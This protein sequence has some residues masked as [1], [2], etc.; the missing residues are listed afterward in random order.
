MKITSGL[1]DN[2]V[3]QRTRRNVCDATV[4]GECDGSGTVY[5]DVKLRGRP[6]G[7]F[8]GRRVGTASQGRFSVR[9]KG[10]ASGG[11]YTISLRL[12]DS[13]GRKIDYTEVKNV[14]VG[15]VW[16]LAGQS[17]MEGFGFLRD[18]LPPHPM[19]RAFSMDSTWDIA[20]DPIHNLPAAAAVV[21][22][23]IEGGVVRREAH[24]GVGPGM[25]FGREMH[26][27]TGVPQGLIACAHGGTS[28]NQ[29]S[30]RLIDLEDRSLYGAMLGRVRMN[31]GQ[32]AGMFWHQGCS[33]TGP[34]EASR[35]TERM[36]Q[37]VSSVRKDLGR[38]D[39]PLVVCQIARLF[40]PRV[41]PRYWN[42]VRDQQRLLPKSIR[43]L[44]VVATIDLPL[45]DIVHLSGSAQN[46]LG[47]R[48]AQAMATLLGSRGTPGPEPALQST[49]IVRDPDSG[50]ANVVVTYANVVGSL[51]SPGEPSGFCLSDNLDEIPT[52]YVYRTDL[53]GNRAILRTPATVLEIGGQSLYYGFGSVTNCSIT[54]EAGRS[55]PAMGPVAIA[56]PRFLTPFVTELRVS[57]LL[58]GA[59]RLR[60][61]P[62]PGKADSLGLTKRSFTESFC[63]LHTE[64]DR[65]APEDR[66]VYFATRIEC[67]QAMKLYLHLGYDGPVRVWFDGALTFFDPN[68]TN[69]A[70]PFDASIRL[71][72]GQGMHEVLVALGTNGGRAWGVFI[73]F[74]RTDV[75]RGRRG[76]RPADVVLPMVLG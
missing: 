5:A 3:L 8:K 2:M 28:M 41:G 62:Y 4:E 25:G 1:F 11:Y 59:G 45:D 31:G 35:Y 63:S 39:L 23:E 70:L 61:L 66:L 43:H 40:G 29:W 26:R 65:T 14:L 34:G 60:G 71:S 47:T 49:R 57:E 19:V 50:C 46:R 32:V 52:N 12:V 73:R 22:R 18:S 76:A 38:R 64:I 68:G 16:V 75:P 13:G 44:T 17:N 30:P 56:R 74:E 10:L 24:I 36:K 54:D 48:A 58:A 9:I 7:S 21:H 55:L 6:L 15:D 51:R 20:K 27:I 69:P 33:E 53:D 67:P 37:F 42:A 72:A